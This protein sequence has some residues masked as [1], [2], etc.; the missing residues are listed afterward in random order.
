MPSRSDFR[1]L[2]LPVLAYALI[3]LL[4][5]LFDLSDPTAILR[6]D[7]AEGRLSLAQD[8]VN[9]D[10][11]ALASMLRDGGPPGDYAFHALGLMLGGSYALIGLQIL[12]GA[13]T[14]VSTMGIARSI[15][16]GPRTSAMAGLLLCVLPGSLLSPHVA[17]TES[18]FT[19]ALIASI[20]ALAEAI[21]S[22]RPDL[23]AAGMLMLSVAA[24]IRPQAMLY[25]WLAAI[26]LHFCTPV[27]RRRA[28]SA[29]VVSSLVFPGLWLVWRYID[30]NSFGM[31]PSS[32]DLQVNFFIRAERI[33]DIVSQGSAGFDPTTGRMSGVEFFRL[34]EAHPGATFKTYLSDALNYVLNPGANALFGFYLGFFQTA[35]DVFYWKRQ[36]DSVGIF[37]VLVGM[38]AESWRFVLAFG[39]M[40]FIHLTTLV[41]ALVG[42]VVKVADPV[43]RRVALLLVAFLSMH[44]AMNFAAGIVRWTHRVPVEPLLA[45]LASVGLA[46]IGAQLTRRLAARR[47]RSAQP[48][49]V[50]LHESKARLPLHKAI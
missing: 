45:V 30:Q 12:C 47:R 15:G 38:L 34:A 1:V 48:S 19:V 18:A 24:F 7:R 37:G 35:V 20:W 49:A 46:W 6:G 25:P 13:L 2:A 9:A 26:V 10:G 39:A 32:F 16:A 4:L 40:T 17:V 22:R 50:P 5:F 31:G 43:P 8:L 11:A 27:L 3:H 44:S 14:L 21:R 36:L 28:W 23:A 41:A 29:A 33:E 42:I